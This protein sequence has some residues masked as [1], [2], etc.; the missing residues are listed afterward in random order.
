MA[1]SSTSRPMHLSAEEVAESGSEYSSEEEDY[2]QEEEKEEEEES[3][4]E[5]DD[6]PGMEPGPATSGHEADASLNERQKLV[7]EMTSQLSSTPE[8]LAKIGEEMARLKREL[9]GAGGMGGIASE[10]Q[11]I[12]RALPALM[13]GDSSAAAAICGY[14]GDGAGVGLRNRGIAPSAASSGAP[15]GKV[16]REALTKAFEKALERKGGGTPTSSPRKTKKPF[17]HIFADMILFSLLLFIGMY[18]STE[19]FPVVVNEFV[20]RLILL[21]QGDYEDEYL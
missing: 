8:A 14:N 9:H 20:E 21:S 13:A 12:K 3:D 5:Y 1:S 2:E 10:L 19:S 17:K 7:Q 11:A 18:F 4:D 16:S 15:Q 6:M